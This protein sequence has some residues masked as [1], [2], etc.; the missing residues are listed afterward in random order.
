[1]EI[2]GNC[3]LDSV[4][5]DSNGHLGLVLGSASESNLNGVHAVAEARP[6]L[7]AEEDPLL[8]IIGRDGTGRGRDLKPGSVAG[9]F[10][11]K[12]SRATGANINETVGEDREGIKSDAW[13]RTIVA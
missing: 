11:G 5:E 12:R 13:W 7:D 9:N 3:R 2:S 8:R 1:M 4:E 10:K 6:V